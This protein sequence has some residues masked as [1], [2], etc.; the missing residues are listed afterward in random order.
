[1]ASIAI[2]QQII[3]IIQNKCNILQSST[4]EFEDTE[5]YP[6]I[7]EIVERI[8]ELLPDCEI[9]ETSDDYIIISYQK[10]IVRCQC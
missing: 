6:N 1:M 4:T 8:K 3:G 9:L 7:Q 2:A 5:V 10:R